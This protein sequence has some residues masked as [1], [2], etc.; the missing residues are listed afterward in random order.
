MPCRQVS[1]FNGTPGSGQPGG[2]GFATE[3]DC[4]QACKEG[5]C[6]EGT[7]CSVKPQCQCQGAGQ[8]FRGVGTTCTACNICSC[9]DIPS[10]FTMTFSGFSY[11]Y[12]GSTNS[13]TDMS[14]YGQ[15]L[16]DF[17]QSYSLEL[18]LQR[19]QSLSGYY[20]RYQTTAGNAQLS[21]LCSGSVVQ[22]QFGMESNASDWA[23]YPGNRRNHTL[24]A[25]GSW[26]DQNLNPIAYPFSV[27]PSNR[28]PVDLPP[29]TNSSGMTR[30]YAAWNQ[31]YDYGIGA[32]NRGIYISQV[33]KVTLTPNYTNPL[34]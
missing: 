20:A 12:S 8:T 29:P 11:Q 9:A 31:P 27:C 3:A 33:G 30:S 21:L 28:S 32:I 2:G 1:T 23:S 7:T 18:L 13:L 34:P 17:L 6:C 10:S 15:Q 19:S 25:G 26:L 14:G 4:L 22:I 5:A 24:S 16:T